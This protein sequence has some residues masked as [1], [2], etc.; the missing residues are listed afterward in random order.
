VAE[1]SRESIAWKLSLKIIAAN[2]HGEIGIRPKMNTVKQFYGFEIYCKSLLT[3]ITT[4]AISQSFRFYLC[5]Q[6]KLL[7]QA[8]YLCF[9]ESFYGNLNRQVL[10]FE[11]LLQ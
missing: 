11:L 7:F 5:N 2:R 4:R 3:K 6:L 8:D 1:T 9:D 10:S